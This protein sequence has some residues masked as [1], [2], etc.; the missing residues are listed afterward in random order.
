MSTHRGIVLRA[1]SG[2]YAV[3]D[4]EGV[5]TCKARRRLERPDPSHPEFPVPGD[6]VGWR[7][8]GRAGGHAEGIIET[9][10]PRRSEISRTRFGSKHVV[11]AN[12]DRLVVVV[13]L[14]HPSLDRGLLDRLLAVAER[15]HIEAII[16]LHKI[17]LVGPDEVKPVRHIYEQAGYTVL[18]TSAVSGAGIEALRAALRQHASAFMGLSGAGKSRLIGSLQPGLELRTGS[19]SKNGQGRHTTTRVD[20][21]R[22]DFGALLA[23]TPGLRDFGLWRLAPEDLRDLFP[24]FRAL[25]EECHYAT[26]THRVEPRCAVMAAVESGTIDAGRHGSYRALFEELLDVASET[27]DREGRVRR[28][29]TR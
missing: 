1:H 25:Q 9:V 11:V 4:G 18:C 12:L 2:R 22:T 14:S 20:L 23:D 28:G 29:G 3:L 5:A 13:P 7:P 26:C 24:E 17:D 21:H 27:V 8:L 6:E 16:C 10:F 19:V 15:S